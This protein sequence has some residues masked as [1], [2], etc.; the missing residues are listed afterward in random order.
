MV[1]IKRISNLPDDPGFDTWIAC[2]LSGK[3]RVRIFLDDIEQQNVTVA[4]VSEG[5][6]VR[7]RRDAIG[8]FV[9]EGNEI[10]EET[11]YGRVEI[12]LV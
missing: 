1:E 11:V 7:A 3:T 10:V 5:F 8:R 9:V 4:D 6:I 2:L 12:E